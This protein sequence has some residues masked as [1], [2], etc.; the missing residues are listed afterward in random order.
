[1]SCYI[2]LQDETKKN[3][4]CKTLVCK[5]KGT[6][7][8]HQSC[9]E[10]VKTKCGNRCTIC[11]SLYK[12]TKNSITTYDDYEFIEKEFKSG[13]TI[14]PSYNLNTYRPPIKVNRIMLD[15]FFKS[16]VV[17]IKTNKC[18]VM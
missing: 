5:C 4:F 10:E 15:D 17:E 18:T 8:I 16:N 9:F 2:C 14:K 7:K 11:N 13:Q 1:M 12:I 6:N 3:P